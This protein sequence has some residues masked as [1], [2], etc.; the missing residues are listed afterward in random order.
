MLPGDFAT[1]A[2]D[3]SNN[4]AIELKA[5]ADALDTTLKEPASYQL[6]FPLTPRETGTARTIR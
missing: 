1:P 3:P 5:A 6:Q 2:V 4:P